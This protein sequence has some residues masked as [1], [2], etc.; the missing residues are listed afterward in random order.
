MK[1]SEIEIGKGGCA[2][3]SSIVFCEFLGG[4]VGRRGKVVD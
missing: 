4:V 3:G 1:P 2:R